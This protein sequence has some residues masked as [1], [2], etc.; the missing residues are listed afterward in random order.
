MGEPLQD[1]RFFCAQIVLILF[2]PASCAS[3]S[4]CFVRA[5]AQLNHPRGSRWAA[6]QSCDMLGSRTRRG[7]RMKATVLAAT[8]VAVLAAGSVPSMGAKLT[9]DTA[10]ITSE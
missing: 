1:L 6:R 10:V 5:P 3:P 8:V 2:R 4:Q 7:L 9:R